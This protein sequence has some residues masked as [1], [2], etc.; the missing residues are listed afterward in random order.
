MRKDGLIWYKL[1]R[2]HNVVETDMLDAARFRDDPANYIVRHTYT[3]FHWVSTV[4]LGTDCNY[5]DDGPPILFETM[6]FAKEPHKAILGDEEFEV[7]E[8]FDQVRYRT[9]DQALEGHETMLAAV[10]ELEAKAATSLD[11]QKH[12]TDHTDE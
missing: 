7:H 8:D 3:E 9:W 1:D 5:W 2:R 12:K 11:W 6:V 10:L 4:F